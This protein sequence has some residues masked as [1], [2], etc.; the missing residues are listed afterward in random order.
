MPNVAAEP[1]LLAELLGTAYVV[2]QDCPS[3]PT[4]AQ[5]WRYPCPE[6][7]TGFIAYHRMQTGHDNIAFRPTPENVQPRPSWLDRLRRDRHGLA[8]TALRPGEFHRARRA[9]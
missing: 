7:A 9:W 2:C 5:M 6:C 1:F 4:G 8:R 3:T